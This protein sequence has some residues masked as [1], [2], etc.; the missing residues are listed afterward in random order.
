MKQLFTI[1]AACAC[2][3]TSVTAQERFEL[4]S[5]TVLDVRTLSTTLSHPTSLTIDG[6]G[7]VWATDKN[8]GTIWRFDL[9][10]WSTVVGTVPGKP[11]DVEV[12]LQGDRVAVAY[13]TD[14]NLLV[15]ATYAFDGTELTDETNILYVSDVPADQPHTMAKVDDE[16]LLISV[17]SFDTHVT[18]DLNSLNGKVIRIKIDGSRPDDNPYSNLV[19]TLGHRQLSGLTVLPSDHPTLPGAVY[20]VEPG[21]YSFD[22]INRL[23]AGHHYGNKFTAGFCTGA[24]DP[25][26]DCP[27]A[28][29]N[30]TPSCIT[31]YAHDAI[32]DWK[33]AFLIGTLRQHGVIVANLTDDGNIANIDRDMPADDVLVLNDDQIMT[34]TSPLGYDRIRAL[35]VTDDGRVVVAMNSQFEGESMGRIIVIEN[36][37][38][39]SPTSVNEGGV[40]TIGFNYGPNP[41][42]DVV[43]VTLASPSAS[44]WSARIVDLMGRTIAQREIDASSTSTTLPTHNLAT[45]SYVLVV[46]TSNGPKSVPLMH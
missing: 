40:N 14:D 19:Y 9:G 27:K 33:G 36:T 10:G 23:E 28:T 31:Y 1:A 6:D 12:G 4:Q 2:L 13:T 11:Y 45:G 29:F 5:G 35:T 46:T 17:G 22:E 30:H 18:S 32:P 8:T 43:N 34:F 44:A 7:F 20:A 24:V 16:T 21:A 25:R 42:V 15:V 39:H 38:I 26:F 41:T 37:A 3:C